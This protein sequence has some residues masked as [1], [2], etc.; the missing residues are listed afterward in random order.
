MTEY[1]QIAMG[2]AANGNVTVLTYQD[3]RIHLVGTAHV[4]QRSV[5][6][7][8]RVILDIRPDTVCVELDRSRYEAL[9]DPRRFRHLDVFEVIRGRR[10]A[11]TLGSLVLTSYQ[12]RMGAKLGVVPGAELLAGVT[13]A[14]DV[15]AQLVLADRDVQVTLRRSWHKLGVSDRAQLLLAMV[16]SLF[17]S[18]TEVS[19]EQIEA[20]KDRDTIQEMMTEL[21]KHMSNL[22]VPLIDERDRYLMSMIREAPGPTIVAVV[23]AGHVAGMVAYLDEPIDRP[24]LNVLPEPSWFAP[25]RPWLA[26]SVFTALC[27]AG[28]LAFGGSLANELLLV[29]VVS[30]GLLTGLAMLTCGASPLATLALTLGAPGTALF[31]IV[32]T[33]AAAAWLEATRRRPSELDKEQINEAL[34]SLRAMRHNPFIR[35]LFVGVSA[36]AAATAGAWLAVAWALWSVIARLWQ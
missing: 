31:P 11:F 2:S 32:G 20:L 21:A 13:T 15:G 12:R 3:K 8:K 33:S 35:I 1:N 4:S 30:I 26:P 22:Q 23:G 28:G 36:G 14:G 6:E 5:D 17:A 19:E 29:W 7:V 24:K 18:S 9:T 16:L 27:V 25:Y 10:L 34:L